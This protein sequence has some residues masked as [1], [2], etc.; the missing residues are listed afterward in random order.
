MVVARIQG[1]AFF[2]HTGGVRAAGSITRAH[3]RVGT[4]LICSAPSFGNTWQGHLGRADNV[5]SVAQTS[6][7]R[8]QAAKAECFRAAM[9]SLSGLGT[10]TGL[11]EVTPR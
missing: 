9:D 4:V 3:G 5:L 6:A 1:A 2:A 7:L 11:L 10:M 8:Q